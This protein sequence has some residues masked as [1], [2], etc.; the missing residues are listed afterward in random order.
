MEADTCNCCPK[1]FD[2]AYACA[3][4]WLT[5]WDSQGTHRTGTAGAGALWLADE[6][7]GLG[8]ETTTEVFELNRLVR[9]ACY[10]ELDGER[11]SGGAGI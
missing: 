7:A 10:L 11:I 3:T 2:D 8:V 6:V 5:A 9:V 1:L 4:A